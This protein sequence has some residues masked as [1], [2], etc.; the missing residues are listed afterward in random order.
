MAVKKKAAGVQEVLAE[1][2]V[3]LAGTVRLRDLEGT[4][5]EES[6]LRL[7]PS[8]RSIVVVGMEV[9]P[10]F[11]DLTAH[12]RTTGA[13]NL[14][15]LLVRH[16]EYLRGRLARAVYDVAGASH[17]AGL[18]A[19]PLPGYGPSV[20][21]RS[22]QAVIS[23]KHA[24]EAAGLGTIGMSSLLVTR[25][26]GPRVQ[27]ALCLTEAALRPSPPAARACRYCNVCISN[28]PSHALDWP[29]KGERYS[30]NKFACEAYCAAAG[31]CSECMRQ[32]PVASPRYF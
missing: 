20:D 2:D 10:E 9:F 4:P 3:D 27:I 32:C 23:Y 19:L 28:C 22:L 13:A 8:C 6:A 17:R 12:E 29:K 7:L 1:L 18:K 26:F 11:L 15:D 16:V 30:I 24:A 25:R 14:N 21:R 31:G 5:L